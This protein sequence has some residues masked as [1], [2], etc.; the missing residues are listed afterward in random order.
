MYYHVH[1]KKNQFIIL[2]LF[3]LLIPLF[4]HGYLYA[5]DSYPAFFLPCGLKTYFHLYCPGCGGTHA[6]YSLLH[7]QIIKSLQ[8][9]PLVLYMVI[10][11]FYYWLKFL[12]CLIRQQGDAKFYIH[13]GSLWGFLILLI[14]H[15]IIRN[16]LLI[17]FGFDYLGDLTPYWN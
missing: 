12:I 4:A 5:A 17:H 3:F 14:V 6:V 7:L 11:A 16:V 10:C 9:N 13:L 1:I 8:Y 2:T 15:T